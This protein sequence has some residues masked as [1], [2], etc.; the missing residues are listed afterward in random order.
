MNCRELERAQALTKPTSIRSRSQEPG[1]WYTR[2]DRA[3]GVFAASAV[4][5]ATVVRRWCL[6]HR[7][8]EMPERGLRFR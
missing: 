7:G 4:S 3:A 5:I 2:T 1:E 8:C 6:E